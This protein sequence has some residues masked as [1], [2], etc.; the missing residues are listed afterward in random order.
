MAQVIGTK[1]MNDQEII[2]GVRR[3]GR[4]VSYI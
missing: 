2:A 4:F 1:G 3:G